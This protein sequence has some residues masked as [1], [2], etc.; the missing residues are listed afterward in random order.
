MYSLP[1]THLFCMAIFLLMATSVM[2][3]DST[4]SK[5]KELTTNVTAN[6]SVHKLIK[7]EVKGVSDT[8]TLRLRIDEAT[9]KIAAKGY[10]ELAF[11]EWK[12][13][14]DLLD[15]RM[16]LG[17]LYKYKSI[18]LGDL[19]ELTYRRAGFEKLTKRKDPVDLID[20]QKRIAKSLDDYQNRGY[21]FAS[22][23]MV[24][25][26]NELID[27]SNID[28]GVK[29]D[30]DPG[31]MVRMDSIIYNGNDRE[32]AKLIYSMTGL[33][34]GDLFN[35]EAIDRIPR[36]LNN[37]IY[38]RKVQA[39][40]VKFEEGKA[41]L[42]VDLEQKRAGKFDLLLGILPPQ[43]PND[44]RFN[45][46]GLIDFRLV[47][48]F[49]SAGEI[50]SFRFDKLI[51]TSQ[52]LNVGYIHSH[53]AGSALKGEFEFDLLK[54]DT[55][56]LNRK[57]GVAGHF[58]F[59]PGFSARG[60]FKSRGSNIIDTSPYEN[61]SVN[62]PPILDGRDQTV[63]VGFVFENIDYR[64]NPTRGFT[65]AADFGL[66]TKRIKQNPNLHP[67]IYQGVELSL[68]KRETT[69]EGHFYHQVVKRQ[70]LHLANQTYW[71]D[72]KQYFRNDLLLVGGAHSIR[73]FNENQFFTNLMSFFTVEYRYILEQNS[74]LF[75]F[76]DWAY[77]QNDVDQPRVQRPM[78]T[79]IGMTYETKA[80]MVTVTYAVGRT[81]QIAFQPSRGRIHVGLVNLF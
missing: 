38:F 66:G 10:L 75:G 23:N 72:Q 45:W 43:D 9:S 29:Y 21:P 59:F 30:F 12:W 81:E 80:G 50:L 40:V 15:I 34:P 27:S 41:R 17:P 33:K 22:L 44:R 25:M 63:G 71:L 57:L 64:I 11:E 8:A 2:G 76:F 51:G 39:P 26:T 47:S 52:K 68:P 55:S 1:R 32:S 67:D 18:D 79:G 13:E 5:V 6:A 54:Q 78:G 77:L 70:V 28:F 65:I 20:L 14:K 24:S 42:E 3:Q 31:I 74:F 4:R 37:S 73:G 36:V 62:R 56:F 35:Q 69:F 49:F 46:T 16:H 19:N 53:I 61:D 58:E 7:K 48:P 60:W